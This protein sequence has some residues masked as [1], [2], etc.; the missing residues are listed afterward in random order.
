MAPK[1]RR[2]KTITLPGRNSAV[3][4]VQSIVPDPYDGK[5]LAV[6]RNSKQHPLE[7]LYAH[8]RINDAQKAAGDKFLEIYDAAEIG[9]A[10]A[11]DYE[12]VKVDVSFVHRGIPPQ[13]A[14][15]VQDLKSV[16]RAVGPWPYKLLVAI[17]GERQM[18]SEIARLHGYN[19]DGVAL[20]FKMALDD[21]S[22]HIG[23]A[24]G[25]RSIRRDRDKYDAMAKRDRES[26]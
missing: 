4:F 2:K 15:A 7:H 16:H 11:I 24:T 9:G 19:R 17:I 21:L 3:E 22:K 13:T 5:P 8:K 6:L 1:G 12:R 20:S 14:Q 18:P 25:P 10:R 23:A 26:A